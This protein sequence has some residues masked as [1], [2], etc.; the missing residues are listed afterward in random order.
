MTIRYE[1]LGP[2]ARLTI[3]RPDALNAFDIPDLKELAAAFDRAAA[4]DA[5]R[6]LIL[7]GT[8]R[9]FS[10]GADIKAMDRMTAE[11]FAEAASLYQSLAR[12]AR[13]LAKPIVGALNGYTLGGGLEIALICDLR[14]AARSA[15]I[16]LPD[17]ELGFSPTG[18]LTYL[19]GRAVGLGRALHLAMTGEMLDAAE[20]ERIGLVTKVVDDEALEAE[21]LALGEQLASYPSTGMRN[22]KHAFYTAAEADFETVLNLEEELDSICYASPETR[23]RLAAFLASRK[24]CKPD[25]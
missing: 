9:A 6:V 5:V 23:E 25:G 1:V 7:T 18:G 20:A 13:A 12:Q 22:I 21:A 15:R 10:V 8:G 2:L 24:K 4:D 3:D 19:M 17:A 14:I 11:E 16:G